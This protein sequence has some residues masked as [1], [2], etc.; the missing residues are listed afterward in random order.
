[1]SG[2]T[3]GDR[4]ARPVPYR[5][6]TDAAD[7]REERLT[8]VDEV[9]LARFTAEAS[10]LLGTPLDIGATLRHVA[11]L[12][13]PDIADWCTIELLGR[14]GMLTDVATAHEDPAQLELIRTI[15]SRYPPQPDSS[16][17]SYAVVRSNAPVLIPQLTDDVLMDAAHDA[18]H[19]VL[20]QR[21]HLRSYLAL[22]LRSGDRVLGV[23]SLAN[24]RSGRTFGPDEVAAVEALSG[25]AGLAIDNAQAFQAADRFRRILDA[26]AEA[27]F[28]L[29]PETGRIVDANQTAAMLLGYAPN[30]LPGMRFW[31]LVASAAGR[32]R[33]GRAPVT[34]A[35]PVLDGTA[36]SRTVGLRLRHADGT[37][38]PVEV[39]L[40]RLTLPGEPVGLVAI[41]RDTRE[42][43]DA[44]VRLHRLAE[45]EHAR[46][47]EL[48]A[49]IR[50]IGDGVVVCDPD[51][52]IRLANPAARELFAPVVPTT[53]A[54]IV[55]QLHDHDRQAPGL[56]RRGGPVT[57]PTRSDRERWIEVATYP[58]ATGAPEAPSDGPPDGA[59]SG[60]APRRGPTAGPDQP[61]LV[62]QSETIVVLRDVTEARQREAV[63]ETFIGVLSH[64]L[65]TPITTIY[66]GS[67]LLSRPD[68]GLDPDTRRAVFLDIADE[69]ERLQRLV[70]DVV[71]L[72]RFGE[73][74]GDLGQEPVLLQ[75][76]VPSVV[77]SE[78]GRWPAVRFS[79]DVPPGLPTVVA[80]PTYV[81]QAVRN[82]LANAAKYSGPD[83][84]VDVVLEWAEDEVQVR[85]LDDGP[86][87]EPDEADRLFELFYRSPR[88]SGQTS[89]AGIGL[90]VCARLVRAMGGRVWARPRPA[91]GSEFGFSL[92]IMPDD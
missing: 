32:D 18:E 86:G 75:R 62:A 64:E 85:I 13:V 90:F 9:A 37:P 46:A 40:Q 61:H 74:G 83:A 92:R 29:E 58:V 81:E 91:G 68:S 53:Y 20:L 73:E 14:D 59:G 54:E 27:V 72:N 89:G 1:M 82:L 8:E 7:H 2:T 6:A 88:T 87:I 3:A 15:R 30:A 34:L 33:D 78:E 45:A 48:H 5:P 16:T 31:D 49:V 28:L 12:A 11:S 71:A 43:V 80:D 51:G 79:V 52:R 35:G 23:M 84:S 47:A 19:A 41:A 77:R 70:E 65:R 57:L 76:V 21:L 50:A 22:P 17:G 67:K 4:S 24:D 55:A 63:R 56:G 25:R 39:L 44:Q 36:P 26:V 60:T 38:L 42:R 10:R 69:A 66:G